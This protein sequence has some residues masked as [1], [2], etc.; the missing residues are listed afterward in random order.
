VLA[1][2][3]AI[4]VAVGGYQLYDQHRKS[5]AAENGAR[6]E[7]AVKLIEQVKTDDA[8]KALSQIISSGHAG[9]ASLAQLQLAGIHMKANRPKDAL[10]VFETLA[11][12]PAADSDI[13]T[14]AQL[15]AAAL[16]LGEGDFTE[17]QNRLKPI[18]EGSTPWQFQA[19]ELL[20]TAAYKAGKIEEA[21]SALT[22]LIADPNAP[23]EAL[24][25][26]QLILGA[27]AS[28]EASKQAAAPAAPAAAAPQ[29]PA[30]G[31][32]NPSESGTPATGGK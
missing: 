9:Y 20:G 32:A 3:G 30:K 17:L 14:F 21:R 2:A 1:A 15:Q 10:A 27:I 19:R 18:A 25:R 7:D 26:I 24:E 23:R 4:V 5:V 6:Y 11:A 31:E 29:T 16:R 8:Q 12:N 22:P 13:R 28:A